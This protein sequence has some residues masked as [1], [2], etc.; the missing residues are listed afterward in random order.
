MKKHLLC[1]FGGI[2]DA[3]ALTPVAHCIRKREPGCKVDFAVRGDQ[4]ELFKNLDVFDNVI[5]I[6]RYPHPL[7]G[8]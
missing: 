3:M 8:S 6:R 4:R 2:G 1:R 5:E 7:R